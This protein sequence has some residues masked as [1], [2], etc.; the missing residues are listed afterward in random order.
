MTKKHQKDYLEDS[1]DRVSEISDVVID[2]T[3]TELDHDIS[4]DE[5][6][7]LAAYKPAVTDLPFD[8]KEVAAIVA[9]VKKD[10]HAVPEVPA[11][12]AEIWF[13]PV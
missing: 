10:S 1:C 3:I 12:V 9:K 7:G 5:P 13:I 2:D 4:Q 11:F 8:P 6:V